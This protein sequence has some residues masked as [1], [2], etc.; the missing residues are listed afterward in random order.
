MSFLESWQWVYDNDITH[1][2]GLIAGIAGFLEFAYKKIQWAILKIRGNDEN[3]KSLKLAVGH[4]WVVHREKPLI[5][6]N[7]SEIKIFGILQLSFWLFFL[8][9]MPTIYF[10]FVKDISESVGIPHTLILVFI[11]VGLFALLIKSFTSATK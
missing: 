2:M 1:F 3:K 7:S 4:P 9:A 11:E 6:D 8:I 5:F 10:S